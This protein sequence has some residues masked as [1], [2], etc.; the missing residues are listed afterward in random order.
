MPDMSP[1][2]PDIQ[3]LARRVLEAARGRGLMIATAESCTGGLVSG[4]LT[5][6][7]GSSDVVA[8]GVVSYSNAVKQALLGVTPGLLQSHGAVSEPVARAMAEGVVAALDAGIGVSITGV[9]GPGGGGPGKPVGLVHFAT[10]LRGAE[11]LAHLER[12]GDIGRDQ[13]RMASV[14][15]ALTLLLQRLDDGR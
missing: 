14:R 8:G 9:A 1:F 10:A 2:P 7:P 15:V 5:A 12:F 11:V 4:A 6:V 13:V 3:D